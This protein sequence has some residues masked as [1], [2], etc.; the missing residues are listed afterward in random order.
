MSLLAQNTK[1]A[2]VLKCCNWREAYLPQRVNLSDALNSVR[3]LKVPA[4][5]VKHFSLA[6]GLEMQKPKRERQ[7]TKSLLL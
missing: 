1:W 6:L 4:L 7:Y 2:I 5:C 3:Q